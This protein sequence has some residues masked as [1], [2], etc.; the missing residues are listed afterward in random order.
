MQRRDE[1]SLS[2]AS[3]RVQGLCLE[4]E[5]F[6]PS[7]IR[8]SMSLKVRTTMIPTNIVGICL[9]PFLKSFLHQH[10]LTLDSRYE[11]LSLLATSV[12]LDLMLES[13]R[14]Q[15]QEPGLPDSVREAHYLHSVSPSGKIFSIKWRLTTKLN[16][17]PC[18]DTLMPA[19]PN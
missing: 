9:A 4:M 15:R 1:Q 13:G 7:G 16:T 19:R 6:R 18:G 17:Q 11:H 8:T 5:D 3:A 10:L 12:Q 14:K 2:R